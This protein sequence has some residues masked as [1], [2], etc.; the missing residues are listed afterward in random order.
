LVEIMKRL[1]LPL[2]LLLLLGSLAAPVCAQ[3]NIQVLNNLASLAFPE[4]ITFQAE[5]TAGT[6]ISS[7]VLEYGVDQLTCGTVEARAFP[8]FTPAP[9]VTAQWTWEMRQSGSLPPGAT[10]WWR[11]LVADSSGAQT[12]T[13]RKTILWL[14]SVH[15]WQGITG[16]GINL[17][18]YNGSASFGQQLHTAATQALTRLSQ[19]VG[20]TAE[21][22]V[23]IYI[24]ANSN[25]LQEAV[26]YAPSWVGGQAFAGNNIVI[27][28]IDPADLEWGKSTEAHELTHVL[29][30]HL[31][32]TCLGFIPTWLSEGLA[33]YGEGGVQASDQAQF[34]QAVKADTLPSLRA[35]TG[36][37]SEESSRATLSY[38]TSYSVVN[39]LIKTYG[40]AKMTALLT[41]LRDGQTV[42]AALQSAY[43]F[44]LDGLE[45]AWRAS[46]GAKQ[47]SGGA[48]PTPLPTPT[49]V[50][51]FVPVGA[52]PVAALEPAT[53]EPPVLQATSTPTAVSPAVPATAAPTATAVPGLGGMDAAALLKYG[54]ICLALAAVLVGLVVV[55]ILIARRRN[56][57]PQ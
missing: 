4:T 41:N 39:F 51:T 6:D 40:R 53:P 25:D 1:S 57:R 13:P 52:A 54:L 56:G 55:I 14:D 17:H 31:T 33:M 3:S 9:K 27:I 24:Y 8:D 29:V 43:G 7:I 32:F 26:L 47:S 21:S 35:L 11:W 49:Q 46:I 10:V 37:F 22:P 20:V 42:E 16:G 48:K 12:T 30:G 15:K 2:L 23:D 5:I 44:D 36:G 19:D 18:Y 45:S 28:G 34:D 50:P 38:T